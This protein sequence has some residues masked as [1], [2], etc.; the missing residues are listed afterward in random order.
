MTM[1]AIRFETRPNRCGPLRSELDE[2]LI[3]RRKSEK[4]DLPMSFVIRNDELELLKGLTDLIEDRGEKHEAK[5]LS[6]LMIGCEKVPIIEGSYTSGGQLSRSIRTLLDHALTADDRN[7][8]IVG[9]DARA[10]DGLWKKATGAEKP[11]PPGRSVWSELLGCMPHHKVPSDLRQA[12]VGESDA[13]KALR[14]FILQAA[15]NNDPVLIVGETGTG[16]DVTAHCIRDL[17]GR[18]EEPF[19]TVN[20]GAIPRDLLET[21]LFGSV[22]GAYTGAVDRLGAWQMANRGT[23]FLDEIG[24]LAL[25]HQ[26]KVLRALDKGRVK[27]VGADVETKVN[28]R[29]I[30]AT[31]RNLFAMM[32][33]GLFREDLY[34]RI[35]C[36]QIRTP[37][38]SEHRED[39]PML[40]Q[41][42]WK[43]ITGKKDDALPGDK[44]GALPADKG[45]AL[46]ADKGD[47]LPKEILRE[48]QSRNWPGN[49]RDLQAVLRTLHSWYATE[50]LGLGH[51]QLVFKY[52]GL[53]EKVDTKWPAEQ[54]V[55]LYSVECL[56][57]LER[58]DETVRACE[59]LL[60]P[61]VEDRKDDAATVRAVQAKL[62]THLVDLETLCLRPRLFHRELTF[63]VIRQLKDKLRR[64]NQLL[65]VN[66]NDAFRFW[67]TDLAEQFDLASHAIFD[68]FGRLSEKGR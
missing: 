58:T 24:D 51:L 18:R 48:L 55:R 28:T 11:P 25:D 20:C 16:K 8:Y 61:F 56:R 5:A 52:Y 1:Q 35:R 64:F 37:A 17:S 15:T 49:A 29:I 13:I 60:R 27:R 59:V 36:F 6:D 63:S 31:N 53:V 40:A 39:I 44:D 26:V 67:K 19:Q 34:Y 47:E 4:E 23:L 46:P 68:E 41:R 32:K 62:C 10:F 3:R 7:L 12:L 42:F 22:K 30:A 50:K 65:S 33:T 14:Q 66:V 57:N 38:L 43:S 2:E 9:A 54:E 45:G 21:E